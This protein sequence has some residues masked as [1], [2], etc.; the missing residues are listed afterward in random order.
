MRQTEPVMRWL[1][2]LVCLPVSCLELPTSS[3]D[4]AGAAGRN[5]GALSGDA[6]ATPSGSDC[7]TDSVSRITICTSISLCPG[8]AVDHELYPDCGFRVSGTSLDLECLCGDYVCPVGTA[9]SCAGARQLLAG[10]TEAA[11]CIQQNDGRCAPRQAAGSGSTSTCDRNCAE[12]C[13]SSPGC[14]ELCGC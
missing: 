12:N 4:D 9:L 10:S 11:V 2:L 13:G 1:W 3:V 8:L 14:L 6:A 5:G 7:I